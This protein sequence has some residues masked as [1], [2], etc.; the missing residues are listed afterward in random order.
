MS[1]IKCPECGREVSDLAAACPQCGCPLNQQNSQPSANAANAGKPAPRRA[2][3]TIVTVSLLIVALA[4]AGAW[5]LFFRGGT[6]ED[7][8][9]AYEAIMRYQNEKKL[10]SLG[11]ALD[12]YLDTYNSD[13]YHF[14][15]IKELNDRYSTERA[16]WNAAEGIMSIEAIRHFVDLHPDGFYLPLAHQKMDS[17]S[18]MAAKAVDTREAYEQ[19]INQFSQGKYVAEARAKMEDLDNV[20]ITVDEKLSA[21]ETLKTHFN[22]LADNNRGAITA[23]LA[24]Q[25]NS[26]IGKAAPELE[27]IYAYMQSMHSH[28][29]TIVFLVKNAEV[30]KVNVAGKSMYNVQFL[31]DEETYTHEAHAVL[32]TEAGTSEE[33]EDG[34][35]PTSTKHFTG[36][37]VLNEA[38]KITSLVLK[39]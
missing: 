39:Q 31:L 23:T 24:E 5:Y 21:T 36:A 29:R 7:E 26:Y 11:V 15:Q 35:K 25:I 2:I 37:A 27:D 17:L 13:A 18:Y 16:D 28:S 12:E 20:E 34:P 32:D 8:R 10:D 6:D 33:A 22:A 1:L 19:Y 38:M 9:L 4:A 30:T 3:G 14:S